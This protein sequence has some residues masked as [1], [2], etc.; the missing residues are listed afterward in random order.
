MRVSRLHLPGPLEPA[1]GTRLTGDR[2]HYVARVLRLKPGHELTVFDGS[3]GEYPATITGVTR[4]TVE[5]SLGEHRSIERESPLKV[6][7]AL[8]ISRGERM[9]LAVQKSVEL[10][11]HIIQP[12]A[13][14]RCG[15]ALSAERAARR[16]QHWQEVAISACE[17]CGRNRLA[18]VHP[19]MEFGIWLSRRA[20]EPGLVLAPDGE[21]SEARLTHPGAWLTLLVGPEGGL[22]PAELTQATAGGFQSV[23]LGPRVLRTETAAIAALATVQA[24]WGDLGTQCGSP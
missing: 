2:A 8:G 16:R 15:V 24:W 1:Q 3:G 12:L 7:L 18:M 13:T 21:H 9:D 17:Q 23:R 14:E 10:G 4:R 5:I 19:M 6:T 20:P 22:S 11:V